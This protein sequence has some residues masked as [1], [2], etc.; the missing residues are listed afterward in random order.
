MEMK[1][2]IHITHR[3]FMMHPP[4]NE[5]SKAFFGIFSLENDPMARPEKLQELQY[6]DAKNAY[7]QELPSPGCYVYVEERTDG[8]ITDSCRF[9]FCSDPSRKPGLSYTIEK[10]KRGYGKTAQMITIRWKG[11]GERIHRSYIWLRD[12]KGEKYPFITKT[13]G[14]KDSTEEQY[15]FILPDGVSAEG[16]SLEFDPLLKEK[17]KIV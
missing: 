13:I 7:E 15:I 3:G 2:R 4:N 11:P 6:W 9:F 16:F 12:E 5:T 14:K 8:E 1:D 10:A 17:Y